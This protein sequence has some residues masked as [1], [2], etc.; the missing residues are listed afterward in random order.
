MRELLLN[1]GC[2]EAIDI[3]FANFIQQGLGH[4]DDDLYLLTLLV[5]RASGSQHTGLKYEEG[6]TVG[7]LLEFDDE[8]VAALKLPQVNLEDWGRV[9]GKPGEPKPLLFDE[10][11]GLIYLYRY[12]Q[13]EQQVAKFIRKRVGDGVGE[14]TEKLKKSFE[15][16]F[17]RQDS[18]PIES[19]NPINWQE[20]AA[21]AALNSRFTVISGGPGTGKTTT[22]AKILALL[23]LENPQL[24]ID[25]VAPTG[26]AADRLKE[27]IINAKN[28]LPLADLG[29]DVAD[30]PADSASTIHRFLGYNPTSGYRYGKNNKR[31]TQ[32]LLVDEASMVSVSLFAKLFDALDDDCR[33]ILL[34]DKDQLASVDNGNVLG[35]ITAAESINQFSKSFVSAYAVVA[36]SS[37]RPAELAIVECPKPLDN[38]VVKLEFSYR[39]KSDGG[40]GVLSKR[41]NEATTTAQAKQVFLDL[42]SQDSRVEFGE[43]V[44]EK[45]LS[46]TLRVFLEQ[47]GV[48]EAIKSYK[49]ACKQCKPVDA[50]NA[51][52]ELRVLCAVNSG[53]YG[54][55]NLNLLM[56]SIYFGKKQE[57]FYTGRPILVTQ[58]DNTLKLYNGDIGVLLKDEQG[59]FQA[60][61]LSD[62]SDNG[63][64]KLSPAYLPAH[65]TAFATTI[66]KSQGSE[67][68]H[69]LMILPAQEN[70]LLTKE[71]IYTGITRATKTITIWSKEDILEK[72]IV[73]RTQ[74]Y[75]GLLNALT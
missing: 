44:T 42:P 8:E 11:A 60:Y 26:K 27:S 30:I 61:F 67:F 65:Q 34:G 50:L 55:D 68:K 74:R 40:I 25:L 70:Q 46:K 5:S 57:L 66:H 36:S 22:V 58:N 18:A 52:M 3:H 6:L 1:S 48:R 12:W 56:E 28:S 72:A 35:D 53:V 19:Y 38:A 23:V 41:V 63:F 47:E 13:D 54:V 64:K 75:S 7:S 73:N 39:F 49:M 43:L 71:I 37:A 51:M 14:P 69:V 15:L 9:M 29:L 24:K 2:F 31:S 59:A 17:A 21:F 32:L 33:V 62:E 10:E 4:E 16:L 45:E 20:V